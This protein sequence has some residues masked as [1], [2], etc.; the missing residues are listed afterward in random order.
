MLANPTTAN[1]QLKKTPSKIKTVSNKQKDTAISKLF[2]FTLIGGTTVIGI[3]LV[4]ETLFS[5]LLR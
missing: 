3:F 2:V 1:I 4:A 5:L